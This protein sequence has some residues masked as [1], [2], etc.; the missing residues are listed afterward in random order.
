MRTCESP[1]SCTTITNSLGCPPAALCPLCYASIHFFETPVANRTPSHKSSIT[2]EAIESYK[3]II[4][5][6][7]ADLES[8]L[9]TIDDKLQRIVGQT[10]TAED[11]DTLELRRIKENHISTEKC[12]QICTQF[13]DHIDQ[14]QLS[15]KS[16]NSS[17]GL[18]GSDT[19]PE[20]VIDKSLQDCKTKLADTIT[21]LE[22][23]MQ[24][25]TDRLLVKSKVAMTSEQDIMDLKRLQDEWQT[26]HQCME[27]CSKASQ[28]SDNSRTG[29]FENCTSADISTPVVV[30]TLERL[31]LANKDFTKPSLRALLGQMSDE[32]LQVLRDRMGT[33]GP[34][35]EQLKARKQLLELEH[36]GMED[37]TDTYV[38]RGRLK[39]AKELADKSGTDIIK[40]ATSALDEDNDPSS[41]TS[42]TGPASTYI[43]GD[44]LG[45]T[46]QL[47]IQ[48]MDGRQ[49]V[50]GSQAPRSDA[51][52]M[53]QSQEVL[54]QPEESSFGATT[55]LDIQEQQMLE[56]KPSTLLYRTTLDTFEDEDCISVVSDDND[57]ASKTSTRRTQPEILAVRHIASF[58][59]E[60]EELRP[61]HEQALKKLGPKRFQENYRRILKFYVLKLR[62]EAQTT[63]QID[64]FRVLKSRLNRINV[65]RQI[66]DLI[67]DD[68]DD[69]TKP[70]DRLTS[71]PV[72]KQ[73]LEDWIRN[74]Y[75]LHVVDTAVTPK[76]ESH[77]QFSDGSDSEE[78]KDEYHAKELLFP[79]ITHA[80]KFLYSVIPFQALLLELRLL[81]LPASLREVVESTPKHLIH[82]SPVND[83]SLIN[84]A[85][86]FIE[87]HTAFE[88]DWWPLMPRVPE[89][90]P[91]RMRLQWSVSN[92]LDV[93]MPFSAF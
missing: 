42:M 47:I 82:V 33:A 76:F 85:K 62:N 30:S 88:W 84:M 11:S 64:I 23:H 25:L 35:E 14:I 58:L 40:E 44:R 75:G 45:E 70:L 9:E 12:L 67:R 54:T 29:I 3:D 46:E 34:N 43:D 28:V 87:G 63:V 2:A 66:I 10:V 20:R 53:P 7:K 4:E 18:S 74:I 73:P 6:A 22:K 91:G 27:I 38:G 39:E 36:I 55:L 72:E 41:T 92:P 59:Y 69:S 68:K 52:S 61:L 37:L 48:K 21:E 1:L 93:M 19:Y 89:L 15:T 16:S 8:H 17:A 80:N 13:F 77:E 86:A 51:S 60:L 49:R 50:L 81:V 31:I 83:T 26:G 78:A 32:S 24:D 79:N 5:T 57:I 90:S 65:A 71:Q 56:L